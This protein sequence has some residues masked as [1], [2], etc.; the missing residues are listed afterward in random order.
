MCRRGARAAPSKTAARRPH[1][2]ADRALIT[3]TPGGLN[4]Y[5]YMHLQARSDYSDPWRTGLI[6]HRKSQLQP[7]ACVWLDPDSSPLHSDDEGVPTAAGRQPDTDA[8]K[9]GR[10]GAGQSRKE[11]EALRVSVDGEGGS[12]GGGVDVDVDVDVDVSVVAMGQETR[13]PVAAGAPSV[14]RILHV[15]MYVYIYLY[16]Y[17]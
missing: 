17:I 4:I 5:I 8:L 14:C 3:A 7:P 9:P 1:W 15:Y 12:G 10:S 11:K 6:V 16:L 13:A 2:P